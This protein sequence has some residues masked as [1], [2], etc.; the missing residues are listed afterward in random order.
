MLEMLEKRTLMSVV[1]GDFNGDHNDDVAIAS[2]MDIVGG[3]FAA[4][5]VSVVYGGN[6][7]VG[8]G[9]REPQLL[10]QNKLAGEDRAEAG[11][12]FGH[13]MA[14]GDFNGD[15]FDD[16]A[17]A[18][19]HEDIEFTPPSRQRWTL[20]Y[21]GVIPN[22]GRL[23]NFNPAPL[24]DVGTVTVVFGSSDGLKL[25]DVTVL[26]QALPWRVSLP[27]RHLTVAGDAQPGDRFGWSLDSGHIRSPRTSVPTPED[28][29]IG[30]IGE[31]NES[32]AVNV[33]YGHSDLRFH[34]SQIWRQKTFRRESPNHFGN[35][36]GFAVT[37]GDFNG[38][39]FDDVAASAPFTDYQ[40][41]RDVGTVNVIY[42]MNYR[43]ED[44]SDPRDPALD[45]D[46]LTRQTVYRRAHIQPDLQFGFS[47]ESGA[48]HQ[49]ND[50][51]IVGIPSFDVGRR[52]NVGAV[53][54]F[55]FATRRAHSTRRFVGINAGD[56]FGYSLATGRLN[57][58]SYDDLAIGSPGANSF[59]VNNAGRVTVYYCRPDWRGLDGTSPQLWSQPRVAGVPQQNGRF[60]SS[61]AI[62]TL[63]RDSDDPASYAEY[64]FLIVG[65]PGED[66]G[67]RTDA[68]AVHVIYAS[69]ETDGLNVAGN[70]IWFQGDHVDDE[71]ESY[72]NYG[73][74]VLPIW[75]LI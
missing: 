64:S 13:A 32:G 40:N 3:Q 23:T 53:E 26:H 63:S 52:R 33:A 10:D 42:A 70:E 65:A 38:D 51:L 74:S 47:L 54:I 14:V 8:R 31:E 37:T 30:V 49:G 9:A 34:G 15:G 19:P 18:A 56:A 7:R 6:E 72:D 4:G 17:I 43:S 68:G 60:G 20:P 12:Y 45:A 66:S 58:D 29:V 5:T 1:T 35:Q 22:L 27:D 69:E 28:L 11:D 67:A 2:P 50:D 62:G 71:T 24:K 73:G 25:D 46:G 21:R 39:G 44:A 48:F 57:R 55:D 59:G 75:H 61:L 16:L 36:F 41:I